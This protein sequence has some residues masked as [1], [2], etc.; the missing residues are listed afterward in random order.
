MLATATVEPTL[1][2]PER[3]LLF[4]QTPGNLFHGI[5][6]VTQTTGVKVQRRIAECYQVEEIPAIGFPGRAF[7]VAKAASKGDKE[8]KQ[9]QGRIDRVGS[10]YAVTLQANGLT[11]CSCPCGNAKRFACIHTLALKQLDEAGDLPAMI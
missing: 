9:G 10:V 1:S 6:T 2:N 5:L 7:H 11:S 3:E 4:V 8:T